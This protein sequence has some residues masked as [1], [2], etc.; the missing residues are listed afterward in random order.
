[1]AHVSDTTL[2][3]Y[4]DGELPE[5]ER[6]KVEH[7]LEEDSAAKK[8]LEQLR[9]LSE[10]VK[11]YVEEAAEQSPV[12]DLWPAVSQAIS[13]RPR[14]TWSERLA[15]VLTVRRL[16][17]AGAFVVVVAVAVGLLLRG[18]S[19]TRHMVE[20]VRPSNRV[21]LETMDYQGAP[22]MVFEIPAKDDSGPTTVIWLQPGP[23]DA[24]EDAT[25][26]DGSI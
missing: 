20:K 3:K 26:Q 8:R 5:A 2:A 18:E 15:A 13:E 22:P 19:S 14:E 25:G 9:V 1:M 17:V 24:T 7:V 16:A 21:V 10:G 12:S 11:S 6:P 4:L 23:G